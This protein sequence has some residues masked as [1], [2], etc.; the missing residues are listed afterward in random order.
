MH[1]SDFD[2]ELPPELIAREPIRPR[3][4]SRMMVLDRQAGTFTDST[5]TELPRFLRASDVL[6]LNDTRVIR[7]RIH[8]KLEPL[9]GPTRQVELLFAAP[10]GASKWEVMCK[11]G[12]RIRTGDHVKF[13]NGEFIG[14]FGELR[15]NGLRLL[16]IDS[17]EPV[18][19]LLERHGRMPLPPYINRIDTAADAVD[20]QTVYSS[21]AGAVAAPTAGLHFTQPMLDRVTA[22]GVEI[23]K[24]TLHVGIG[25]F[26]PVRADDPRQHILR[27]ERF[28]MSRETADRLNTA[29]SNGRRVIAVGTTTTRTLEHMANTHGLFRAESGEVDLYILPGYQFKAVTGLLTNFHLPKSTLLMLVS[30]FADRDLILNAYRHAVEHR[31]RFY[32]YGD[33]M[34]I[35]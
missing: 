18:E 10:V 33:C 15:D 9:R 30:A 23:L 5:F 6:V 8:G 35:F 2:Y 21:S 26:L 34:L 3:D 32:S 11:P 16:Q 17:S 25:T 20:Y 19:S 12:K 31:Y 29:R 7:A 4:A 24:I 27:P 14:T 28:E 13:A 1:L 22:I